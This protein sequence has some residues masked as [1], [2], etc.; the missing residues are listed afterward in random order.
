MTALKHQAQFILILKH[1]LFYDF[2]S[3]MCVR[4]HMNGTMVFSIVYKLDCEDV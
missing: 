2:G 1:H 4:F 3:V